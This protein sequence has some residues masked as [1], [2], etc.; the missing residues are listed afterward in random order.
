MTL[1]GGEV[2][3]VTIDPERFGASIHGQEEVGC[4]ECHA[5]ITEY[6]HA[7]L[8]AQT[9]REVTLSFSET[10]AECHEDEAAR[11]MDSIHAEL[12]AEGD[13]DAAT[14]ADCHNPHYQVAV[15]P[16]SR[17]PATCARCHSGIA[18]DYRLSVHGAALIGE[19]NAD[20]PLCI[21]CHGVHTIQDPTTA[22]WLSKS[23]QLCAS[24]HADPERMAPYDLNTEVLNTYVADFH[25]TTAT[26]FE[27]QTPDQ[28]PNTPLCIDCH[29][30]HNIKHVDDA[31]SAV[32]KDNLL[33]TCQKCH[34]NA[35]ENFSGAWLSHYVPSPEHNPLVYYVGIFY[36]IFVPVTVAGMAVFVASDFRRQWIVRR[37]RAAGSTPPGAHPT[38]QAPAAPP[39]VPPSAE[40]SASDEHQQPGDAGGSSTDRPPAA[41]EGDPK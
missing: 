7:P 37:R 8:P 3:Y 21:T 4:R 2:L 5:D 13:L 6:P 15:E 32:I 38:G 11:V 22:E 41:G 18:Q 25:G 24:C 1:A 28:L 34:P 33:E 19:E 17:I 30:I 35:T 10:C 29:G 16:I 31:E 9:L 12:R 20:A 23:P 26:L 39:S 40:P 14:C 36:Q 27:K